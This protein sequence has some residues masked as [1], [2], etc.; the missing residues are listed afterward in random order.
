MTVVESSK[1]GDTDGAWTSG[2]CENANCT[3][4]AVPDAVGAYLYDAG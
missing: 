3:G 1:T 4:M 2:L